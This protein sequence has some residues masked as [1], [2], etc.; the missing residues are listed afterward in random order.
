MSVQARCGVFVVALALASAAG[1]DNKSSSAAGGGDKKGDA[2]KADGYAA[3]L[4]GTWLEADAPADKKDDAARVE[5][6]ADAG[7]KIEMGPF[8]MAGTYKVTKDDGK[9]VT[10]EALLDHPFEKGKKDTKTFTATFDDADTMTMTPT[11]KSDP[12][13][14]KRTK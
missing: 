11:D 13:K 5:F 1:C 10:F 14:F 8:E 2:G 3:K 6:K 12:K 7:M 9:T 4:V